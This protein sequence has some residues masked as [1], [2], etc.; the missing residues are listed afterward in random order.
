MVR[1]H[2]ISQPFIV[3]LMT[4]LKYGNAQ[5]NADGYFGWAK[6][7]PCDAVMFYALAGSCSR[8]VGSL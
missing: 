2:T 5:L 6:H 7:G 8:A 1:L 3:A 4:E